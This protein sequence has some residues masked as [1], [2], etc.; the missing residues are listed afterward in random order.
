[1]TTAVCFMCGEIKLPGTGGAFA[2][3]PKCKAKPENEDD[4]ALALA[5]T[6]HY[7]DHPR[8][9]E[10]S[11]LISSGV[12]PTLPPETREKLIKAIR[13]SN[14]FRM[15]GVGVPSEPLEEFLKNK[16]NKKPWWRF[17]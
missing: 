2:P 6:D 3:C 11:L 5:L 14:L 17:W 1:M 15:L 8:L 16:E 13:E 10:I 12:R 4:F 7:L 9:K